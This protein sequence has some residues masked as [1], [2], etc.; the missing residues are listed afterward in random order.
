MLGRTEIGQF[1][2]KYTRDYKKR[3]WNASMH[4]EARYDVTS[5]LK[6]G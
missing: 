6:V 4:L 1:A 3:S 5:I 2:G